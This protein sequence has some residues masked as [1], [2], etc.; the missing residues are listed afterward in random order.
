MIS[1][2]KLEF[3]KDGKVGFMGLRY[4]EFLSLNRLSG[5]L[6][7][8]LPSRTPFTAEMFVGDCSCAHFPFS[9]SRFE[10]PSKT[11]LGGWSVQYRKQ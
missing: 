11:P 8:F 7:D 4:R 2:W 9:F 10:K 1:P 6:P 3:Q 5:I